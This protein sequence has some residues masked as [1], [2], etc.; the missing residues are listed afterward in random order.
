MRFLGTPLGW[1][2]HACYS[3]VQN[4]GLA[5]IMFT[6]LTRLVLLPLAINQQKSMVKMAMFRP[7][8]E[9]I[10]KKYA[11]NPQR[12]NEELA[13]LYAR[14]GYNPLSGCLPMLIQLPI[15]FGLIDVIYNPLT[16]LLKM[17]QSVVA[18]A[19]EI[20]QQV[21]GQGGMSRYSQEMSVINAVSRDGAA[22][23]ELGSNFV[24]QITNF[25]FTFFGLDM[26]VVPTFALNIFL[27]IPIIS[28]L[29]SFAMSWLSMKNSAAP[30]GG[31][32]AAMNSMLLMMPLMSVWIAFQVPAG[33][34]IYW[35][36]S[37]LV[38]LV[39][40]FVL[41]KVFNPKEQAAK[42]QAALEAEREAE[43]LERQEARKEARE[44][45]AEKDRQRAEIEQ[46]NKKRR[47]NQRIALPEDED[48]VD[49]RGLSQKEIN[50]MKLAAARKRDAEK[51]G[52]EY[53]E[54]EDK[55]LE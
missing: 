11:K 34:G 19:I 44:R 53:V 46:E 54:V 31:S 1:I 23:A 24:A 26:S 50:R 51:Y 27:L 41:G 3:L 42:A 6:I 30:E 52:E 49:E 12:M 8:M 43:R 28:G 5:L 48:E 32:N 29:S 7:K 15:L 13:N 9:E 39:Q 37:N 25:D 45:R 38:M 21:L 47:P 40:Q 55:D 33:V 2:M 4:Y 10:Q 22:F 14:E 16:H 18:R 20:S 35:V 17:D 36:L